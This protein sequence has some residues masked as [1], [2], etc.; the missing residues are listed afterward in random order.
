M[1]VLQESI[2][3]ADFEYAQAFLLAQLSEQKSEECCL[4]LLPALYNHKACEYRRKAEYYAKE[5]LSRFPDSHNNHSNLNEAQ[6]GL[7]GDWNLDNQAERIRYYKEF[8][9]KN[10]DSKESW[11]WYITALLHADRCDEAQEAIL[12]LKNLCSESSTDANSKAANH[13][14]TEI[15]LAQLLWAQG[16]HQES[17]SR[18]DKITSENPDAWLVWNF[19]G[20]AYA[21]ACQYEKAINCYTRTIATQPKPRYT[22]APMAIAQICEITWDTS[23]ANAAWE[24]YIRILNEDWNTTEG[25]YIDRANGKILELKNRTV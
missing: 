13:L 4:R 20:D 24:M 22:D 23:R 9:L 3:D 14:R 17:L 7:T 16:N 1:L 2:E 25:A 10:P 19:A 8:L 5:A 12:K 6:Q 15:Y 11:H 18:F 21:K